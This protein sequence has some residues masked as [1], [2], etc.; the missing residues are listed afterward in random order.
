M[1]NS[2]PKASQLAK[3]VLSKHH[4]QPQLI[5]AF[6]FSTAIHSAVT[7]HIQN[8]DYSSTPL[9]SL[10]VTQSLTTALNRQF[11]PPTSSMTHSDSN[12]VQ[13]PSMQIDSDIAQRHSVSHNYLDQIRFQL[14]HFW[15]RTKQ[16]IF[17]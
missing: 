2:A 3:N 15:T 5:A 9:T 14:T 17:R 4:L 1:R 6:I 16:S 8:T 13:S 11:S 10:N 7:S 12:S